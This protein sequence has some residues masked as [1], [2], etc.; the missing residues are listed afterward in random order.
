[1]QARENSDTKSAPHVNFTRER[2]EGIHD[3]VTTRNLGHVVKMARSYEHAMRATKTR[4]KKYFFQK[5]FVF[6]VMKLT[7]RGFSPLF[8]V[9]SL[10]YSF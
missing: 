2:C 7:P 10:S 6:S 1:M 4:A 5:Y 9:S 8:V 3:H